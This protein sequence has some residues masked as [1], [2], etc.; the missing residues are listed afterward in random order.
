MGK[1]STT[2]LTKTVIDATVARAA[3]FIL[4]DSKLS[5][6]GIRIETTGRKTFIVRYRTEG[7]GRTASRR[8]MTVGKFGTLTLE[9][10]RKKARQ[11]LA[12]ATVGEDPAGD[13]QR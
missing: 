10:A 7:G 1:A 4:W 12:A 2:H 3:R 11:L 6:F 9:D 13:R 5:G 8:F